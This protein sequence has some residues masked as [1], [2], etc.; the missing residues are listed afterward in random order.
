MRCYNTLN[1]EGEKKL[2]RQKKDG[3]EYKWNSPQSESMLVN[4]NDESL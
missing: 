2:Y 1:A 4:A 3:L